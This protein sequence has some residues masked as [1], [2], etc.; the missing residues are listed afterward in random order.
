MPDRC[1]AAFLFD[2]L[3]EYYDRIGELDAL[4]VAA[5]LDH[6]SLNNRGVMHWEIG[7]L[8]KAEADLKAACD[9]ATVDA[10]PHENLGRFLEKRDERDLAIA[11][12]QR[13]LKIDP[14]R[15]TAQVLLTR[16]AQRTT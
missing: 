13:A 16:L 5:P 8:E 7:Q 3:E 10:L 2:E 15:T 9:I 12:Y 11:S 4:L 14:S 1:Y 6:V